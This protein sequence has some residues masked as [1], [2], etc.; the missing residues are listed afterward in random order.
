MDD[1]F[2]I[3]NRDFEHYLSQTYA[4]ELTIKYTTESKMSASRLLFTLTIV[5]DGKLHTSLYD[6]HDNFHIT[7]SSLKLYCGYLYTR[8]CMINCIG[9]LKQL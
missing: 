1:V 3:Y 8:P 7:N 4:A 9:G 2:I 5:M 6:R